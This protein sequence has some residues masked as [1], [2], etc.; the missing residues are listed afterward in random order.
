MTAV[1]G[2]TRPLPELLQEEVSLLRGFVALLQ[3]EQKMLTSG[4]EDRVGELAQQKS[5]QTEQLTVSIRR[6]E[7]ALVAAGWPEGR[8]GMEAWAAAAGKPSAQLWTEFIQLAQEAQ[9]LNTLNGKLIVERLRHNQQAM[10]LLTA[11]A[12]RAALYGPDGQTRNGGSGRTLGS[13]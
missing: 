9:A 11:A 6:R 5:R 2:V 12:N 10:N 13:A 3:D 4:P 8:A 1:N 7:A